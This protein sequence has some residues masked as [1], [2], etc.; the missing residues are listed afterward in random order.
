MPAAD[1]LSGAGSQT[2]VPRPCCFLTS[3]SCPRSLTACRTVILETPTSWC[4]A[5]SCRARGD[6]FGEQLFR[7]LRF[8]AD[9]S[10]KSGFLLN[11]APFD[12]AT[13]LLGGLNF[14]CGSSRESAVWSLVDYGFTCVIASSFADI[15][16]GNCFKNELLPVVMAPE[17]LERLIALVR[18]NPDTPIEIDLG[19]QRV[20][21]QEQFEAV[22][23]IDTLRRELLL[24]GVDELGYTVA[25]LQEIE[26]FDADYERALD[27]TIPAT[28]GSYFDFGLAA[29]RGIASEI[30][31]SIAFIA[32]VSRLDLRSAMLS[33]HDTW[34][35]TMGRNCSDPRATSAATPL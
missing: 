12:R 17:V 31:A 7:D 21:G 25:R 33:V 6:G 2:K 19:A 32:G 14:G 18:R 9:G 34:G 11:R 30:S 8:D 35:R 26:A 27:W 15:F 20:R 5:A 1:R 16:H 28:A 3:P 23:P 24:K 29:A 10:K 22:F 4:P 13:I